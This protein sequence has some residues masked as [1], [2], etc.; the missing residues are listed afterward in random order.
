MGTYGTGRSYRSSHASCPVSAPCLIQGLDT[1]GD[2]AP[3]LWFRD[4][5]NDGKNDLMVKLGTLSG[6][7]DL[8]AAVAVNDGGEIVG[9]GGSSSQN[10]NWVSRAL[11]WKK[12]VAVDLNTLIPPQSVVLREASA[13]T[14]TGAITQKGA[15][16]CGGTDAAGA[17]HGYL[18][19]P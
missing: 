13:I 18:L 19:M 7:T 5:N 8:S 15:I 10:G 3:D 14:Q 4:A 6:Y 12:Q 17:W 11:I 16:L 2:N 1:D 9:Y